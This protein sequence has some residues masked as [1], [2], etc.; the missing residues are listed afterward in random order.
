MLARPQSLLAADAAVA[1]AFALLPAAVLRTQVHDRV[2]RLLQPVPGL[3]SPGTDSSWL[4]S[5]KS[6]LLERESDLPSLKNDCSTQRNSLF[7]MNN[8]LNMK[9]AEHQTGNHSEDFDLA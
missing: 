6:P 1:A 2:S 9:D 3:V 4:S 7:E 8:R 5:S